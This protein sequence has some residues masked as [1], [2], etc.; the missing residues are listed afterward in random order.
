MILYVFL[1][2]L[3][4]VLCITLIEL[5]IFSLSQAPPPHDL[6]PV[7]STVAAQA[8]PFWTM[9]LA[10]LLVGLILAYIWEA[11]WHPVQGLYH[12]LQRRYPPWYQRISAPYRELLLALGCGILLCLLT[13]CALYFSSFRFP[14]WLAGP[15]ALGFS[16]GLCIRPSL[17]LRKMLV[18]DRPEQ[19]PKALVQRFV[20]EYSL[21]RA[22]WLGQI[23][24]RVLLPVFAIFCTLILPLSWGYLY[25][26]L[27]EG[28]IL[29]SS[30]FLG[31]LAGWRA[32]RDSHL[33]IETFRNNFLHL[34]ALSLLAAAFLLFGLGSENLYLLALMGGFSGY[35]AGIY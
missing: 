34:G 24:L 9:G 27:L 5:V 15:A 12:Y 30:L 18:E 3:S 2:W 35:L 17:R 13:T 29:L 14:F 16:L 11:R 26:P 31:V 20:P 32:N 6:G 33:S 10:A 21:Q 4:V 25:L 1:L 19:P 28:L 23:Y 8:G 7:A 22:L